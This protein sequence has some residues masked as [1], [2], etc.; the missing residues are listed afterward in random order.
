M[1]RVSVMT[2]VNRWHSV[3]VLLCLSG[4]PSS[5]FSQFGSLTFNP[6]LPDLDSGMVAVWLANVPSISMVSFSPVGGGSEISFAL[7]T[8]CFGSACFWVLA[9]SK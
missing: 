3:S 8:L 4:A 6:I 9:A 2:A 7:A 1:L 5:A